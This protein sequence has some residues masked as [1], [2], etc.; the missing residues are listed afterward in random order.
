[1]DD[2]MREVLETFFLE[3]SEHVQA[4]NDC[5]LN[6]ETEPDPELINALF[7]SLHTI[8]GNSLMLGFDRL[9]AIA[10]AA[11]SVAAKLRSETIAP[12]RQLMDLLL[13][14]RSEERR[15]GKESRSRWSSHH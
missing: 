4:A 6:Y 13:A 3:L 1:M 5:I 9:G 8:K 12:S 7:R 14:S 11:E 2:D 15:V 10:H